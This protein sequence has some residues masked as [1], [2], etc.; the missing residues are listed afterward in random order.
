MKPIFCSLFTLLVA[1]CSAQSP[2]ID[3]VQIVGTDVVFQL[4]L[5]PTATYMMGSPTAEKGRL[6]NEGPARSMTID[7]FWIGVTEVTFDAYYLFQYLARDSDTT[8]QVGAIFRADAVTRPSPP[9]FDFV[10]GRGRLGGFPAASMTQQAALRYCQWL[11][12]KTGRFF[13]LATEA[14]WEYACRAGSNTPYYFGKV[15]KALSDNAVFYEN[16][17]GSYAKV[18]TKLPNAFGLYDMLGNVAEWTLDYYIDDYFA[19]IDTISGHWVRPMRKHA[20][21]VRG[22][23]FEDYPPQCRCAS[24]Q[25]SDPKWQARD[26]QIP[27]SRWWNPDSPFVGFRVVSPVRQPTAAEQAAFW[28]AAIRD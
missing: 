9:Y 12:Q 23:S 26:P 24:R 10:Y 28:E 11:T 22:G 4:S 7:S 5:L 25:R 27:R 15:G 16:S 17:A 20:R 8:A 18:G 13:R 6:E 14:E 21:T 1:T 2:T 19:Q 3:T